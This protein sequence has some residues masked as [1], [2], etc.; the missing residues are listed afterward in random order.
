MFQV[1]QK[2]YQGD[3]R[4]VAFRKAIRYLL[5][6]DLARFIISELETHRSR[7]VFDI[8][9]NPAAS[10]TNSFE[11]ASFR[12]GKKAGTVKWGCTRRDEQDFNQ[13]GSCAIALM[14][15]LGHVF[16]YLGE[17]RRWK[18]IQVSSWITDKWL[19]KH[20]EERNTKAV[21]W[22]VANEINRELIRL[23]GARYK[24]LEPIRESYRDAHG[25]MQAKRPPSPQE[26]LQYVGQLRRA[27][28]PPVPASIPSDFDPSV[29]GFLYLVET[30]N[31]W[32]GYEITQE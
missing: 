31:D 29:C 12:P 26:I 30:D 4:E 28:R 18:V 7:I 2:P 11:P 13:R 19:L 14:H 3:S 20:L 21:E 27:N 1:K 5:L 24:W 16:Q 32:R 17:K 9:T 23:R 8:G 15:E 6:S 22:T 10:L 25:A